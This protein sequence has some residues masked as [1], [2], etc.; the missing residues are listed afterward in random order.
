[1]SLSKD[2]IFWLLCHVWEWPQKHCELIVRLQINFSKYVNLKI[3]NPRVMS[4][5]CIRHSLIQSA[6]ST[7]FLAFSPLPIASDFYH[8]AGLFQLPLI[9]HI[10][11]SSNSPR[12]H[13]SHKF[14]SFY[15]EKW[16]IQSHS[17]R[18]T[19]NKWL[20]RASNDWDYSL[21]Y[22]ILS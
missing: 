16:Y 6:T 14:L 18:D 17:S 19:S 1:M 22:Y 15:Y 9:S 4:I 3:Q 21:S 13:L 7:L 10:I 5:N 2:S 20:H 11:F 12:L 8:L